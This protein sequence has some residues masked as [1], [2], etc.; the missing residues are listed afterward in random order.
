MADLSKESDVEELF[1]CALSH[2]RGR[3]DLLVNNAGFG[4]PVPHTQPRECYD[5]YVKVMR[6][7]LD[8]AVKLT[9][10]AAPAL[11][12]S[13]RE[14]ATGSS[15]IINIGSISALRPSSTLFAYS[16]S[17]AALSSFTSNMAVELAPEIRVN[18]VAPGPV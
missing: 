12:Q 13:A 3:L 16:T 4:Q 2:F 11:S 1:R 8:A 15:S 7:N 18:C 17:K 5:N 10:L 6:I 14:H 9:L